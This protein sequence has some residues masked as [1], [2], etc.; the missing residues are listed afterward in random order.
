MRKPLPIHINMP[1]TEPNAAD[2]SLWRYM[3]FAKLLDI[4]VT[5]K[6]FLTRL[7]TFDDPLEG[8]SSRS[9]LKAIAPALDAALASGAQPAPSVSQETL[10]EGMK[11]LGA[12]GRRLICV[13][14]WHQNNHESDAMW[15]IYSVLGK[16]FAIQT[17]LEDFRSA[18]SPEDQLHFHRV[19]YIDFRAEHG[20]Q[21]L[22]LSPGYKD[23]SYNHENEVRAAIFDKELNSGKTKSELFSMKV[24]KGVKL[25]VDIN[26]L[27]K[28][29]YVSPNTES[30]EIDLLEKI[31]DPIEGFNPEI[32]P[33]EYKTVP[34]D[35]LP[36][37]ID[38]A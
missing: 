22:P 35:L 33:S 31:V 21:T 11:D 24:T 30:W 6:L 19:Q 32:S 38:S 28:K 34:P 26:C 12:I 23:L 13:S 7:E 15:K 9:L 16:G 29:I 10:Q 3:D 5:R 36:S 20:H 17:T 14:C 4:L 8:R 27:I 37:G 18:F 1:V 25:N 2:G